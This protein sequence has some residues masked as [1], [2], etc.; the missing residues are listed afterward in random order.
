MM[1]FT[2]PEQVT[3]K[4]HTE[5]ADKVI[6]TLKREIDARLPPVDAEN[7]RMH[8]LY[9][10]MSMTVL[11]KANE[12]RGIDNKQRLF[13]LQEALQLVEQFGTTWYFD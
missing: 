11:L 1:K 3:R 10:A 7:L 9:L 2:E 12:P 4:L 8:M 13:Y 5:I 6:E